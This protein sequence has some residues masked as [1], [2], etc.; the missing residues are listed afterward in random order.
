MD[1]GHGVRDREAADHHARDDQADEKDVAD[2]DTHELEEGVGDAAAHVA[3]GAL[4]LHR[5]EDDVGHLASPRDVEREHGEDGEDDE[6]QTERDAS[7]DRTVLVHEEGHRK[8]KHG[9]RKE[10]RTRPEAQGEGMTDRARDERGRWHHER[11]EHGDGDDGE[12]ERNDVVLGARE[13]R[14]SGNLSGPPLTLRPLGPRACV[15]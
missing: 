5:G 2:D 15:P 9:Y 8:E 14:T 4:E 11:D 3:A 6:G 1:L 10:N 13:P 7:G 12:K